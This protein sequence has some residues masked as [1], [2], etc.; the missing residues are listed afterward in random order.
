MKHHI[1]II[2]GINEIFIETSKDVVLDVHM[3]K[4][5]NKYKTLLNEID[6]AY[7]CIRTL[8]IDNNLI[9]KARIHIQNIM[10]LWRELKLPITPSAHLLK[11]HILNQ[12]ETIEG[13]I[14]NKTEDHIE[15]SHQHG[16]RFEPRYKCVTDFTQL[17][18]SQIKLK[19]LLS[20]PI[21]EMKSEQVKFII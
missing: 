5:I 20:N 15:T 11:Y 18:T 16:K 3:C 7:R 14:A 6:E 2:N 8:S 12:M 4:V 9:Y 21:V 17:Q 10:I 1:D 13:G 19:Y